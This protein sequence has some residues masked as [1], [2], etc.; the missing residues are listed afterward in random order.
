M[1]QQFVRYGTSDSGGRFFGEAKGL[2]LRKEINGHTWIGSGLL[3]GLMCNVE[4]FPPSGEEV[5]VKIECPMF[6][7]ESTDILKKIGTMWTGQYTF[8]KTGTG[9]TKWLNLKT[10]KSL[11]GDSE[12]EDW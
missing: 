2:A 12:G 3:G 6:A 11:V 7:I 9:G 8:I 4:V 10:N 1:A 5:K